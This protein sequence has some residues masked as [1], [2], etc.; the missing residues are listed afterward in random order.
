MKENDTNILDNGNTKLLA[1]ELAG[2]WNFAATTNNLIVVT[3]S[4]R[5]RVW[6]K[7]INQAGF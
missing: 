5:S 3:D 7:I 1:E 2:Q 4:S 6:K